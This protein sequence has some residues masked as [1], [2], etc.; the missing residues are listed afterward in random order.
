MKRRVTDPAKFHAGAP[1]FIPY[2][3]WAALT[4][5]TVEIRLNNS[6]VRRGVVD[7]AMPDSSALRLVGAD[8][9]NRRYFS[10]EEGYEAWISPRDL[11]PLTWRE[12]MALL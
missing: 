1:K 6:I 2:D 9:R 4:G 10:K 3:D 12:A 7:I 8:G 5:G 11:Q